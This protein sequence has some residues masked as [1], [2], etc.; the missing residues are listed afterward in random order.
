MDKHLELLIHHMV[1]KGMGAEDIPR[2]IRHVGI[3]LGNSK[4]VSCSMLNKNL[5]D[6]GWGES[7][8]D[9]TSLRLIIIILEKQGFLKV[10]KET[11]H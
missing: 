3:I 7:V 6:L 10:K 4:Y 1:N 11:L 9:E 5:A 8:L 2:L